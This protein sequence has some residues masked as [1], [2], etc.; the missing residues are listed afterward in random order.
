[1]LNGNDPTFQPCTCRASRGAVGGQC[2]LCGRTIAGVVQPIAATVDSSNPV[3]AGTPGSGRPTR[4]DEISLWVPQEVIDAGP[5]ALVAGRYVRVG[6]RPIG[7]G[8]YGEVWKAYDKHLERWV[9]LKII[10]VL[11]DN[12]RAAALAEAKTVGGLR[13]PHIAQLFDAGDIDAASCF[14]AME[15]IDGDTLESRIGGPVIASVRLVRDAALA[16][17]LAHTRGFVHRDLKPRNLMFERDR[18][19]HVFVLDFGVARWMPNPRGASEQVPVGTF[20]YMAPEQASGDSVDARADIYGLGT[21]LYHLLASQIYPPLAVGDSWMTMARKVIEHAAPPVS[22]LNHDVDD[23][24][25]GIVEKALRKSPAER[26]V[27]AHELAVALTTWLDVRTRTVAEVRGADPNLIAGRYRIVRPFGQGGFGNVYVAHDTHTATEVI[28]KRQH[29]RNPH[30]R[31]LMFRGAQIQSRANHPYIVPVFDFGDDESGFPYAV[32][33]WVRDART[34]DQTQFPLV[35]GIRL[36]CDAAVAI[37]DIHELG[38][39]RLDI[40]PGNALV[41][42]RPPLIQLIDFDLAIHTSDPPDDTGSLAGTPAVMS[43]EQ[44]GSGK[45]LDRRTDV[46]ALGATLYFTVAGRYPLQPSAEGLRG[47]GD[48]LDGL[49]ANKLTDLRDAVPSVDLALRDIVMQCLAFD[50]A[51]RFQTMAATADALTA[52]L[53][54]A[55]LDRRGGGNDADSTSRTSA[56]FVG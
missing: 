20:A 56:R 22:I 2:E 44:V 27:S 7:M 53:R 46:F 33:R 41:T 10:R 24:L 30:M 21:T 28:L 25:D 18:P 50:P 38:Y 4:W 31:A 36:L 15:F 1:V 54:A 17:H 47:I 11:D 8:A 13:H 5:A 29:V 16:V 12:A 42:G 52:W 39:Y 48:M 34:L 3:A 51:D 6:K 26:Q 55:E 32:M 35:T 14:L 49:L 37:H 23:E 45:P 19:D 9:A 43:P 40:K